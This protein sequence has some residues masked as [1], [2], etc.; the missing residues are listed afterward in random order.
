MLLNKWVKLF[1][2]KQSIRSHID[3]IH[4]TRPKADLLTDKIVQEV[5][6][7]SGCS[8]IISLVSRTK[9][10]LN[11]GINK[12]NKEA[13]IKYRKSINKILNHLNLIDN[14]NKL[15]KPY[16]HL[17]IHGMHNRKNIDINI[18]TRSGRL[19]QS[20]LDQQG[21]KQELSA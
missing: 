12:T 5:I 2:G 21:Q 1:L 17:A 4:A 10:D 20:Q 19:C 7:K 9:A 14:N 15:K 11:R 13:V 3:A 16:L 18:A 8:G 6:K